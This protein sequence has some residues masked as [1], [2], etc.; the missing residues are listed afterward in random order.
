MF[1]L[2]VGTDIRFPNL[3]ITLNNVGK[4]VKRIR[5]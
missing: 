1:D 2:F 3:G 4:N 5:I